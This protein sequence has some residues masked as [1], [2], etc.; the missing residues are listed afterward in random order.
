MLCV[1][2]VSY[3][4][5]NVSPAGCTSQQ[6]DEK[7]SAKTDAVGDPSFTTV[8]ITRCHWFSSLKRQHLSRQIYISRPLTDVKI[9]KRGARTIY[10][11]PLKGCQKM[12][13]TVSEAGG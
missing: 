2:H 6:C 12:A 8:K 7:Q 13:G 10:K 9:A 4:I 11:T 3:L 5:A 1:C